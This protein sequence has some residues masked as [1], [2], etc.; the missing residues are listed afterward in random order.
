MF[1]ISGISDEYEKI[2]PL[3]EQSEKYE[4]K[5]ITDVPPGHCDFKLFRIWFH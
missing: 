3:F 2:G 1:I 4:N 5:L